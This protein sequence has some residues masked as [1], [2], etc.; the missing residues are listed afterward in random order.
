[1]VELLNLMIA[2]KEAIDATQFSL[3]ARVYSIGSSIPMARVRN[4]QGLGPVI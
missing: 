4:E 3:L 1:M 2:T